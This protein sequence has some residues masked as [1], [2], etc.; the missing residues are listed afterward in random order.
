MRIK[1]R[2]KNWK[3]LEGYL[4]YGRQLRKDRLLAILWSNSE[5]IPFS[6]DFGQEIWYKQH[7]LEG[8]RRWGI[9][10]KHILWGS[11][12]GPHEVSFGEHDTY[13]FLSSVTRVGAPLSSLA[14]KR[15]PL[16]RVAEGRCWKGVW[17]WELSHP[18]SLASCCP[19]AGTSYLFP[20]LWFSDTSLAFWETEDPRHEEC[21]LRPSSQFPPCAEGVTNCP[22]RQ[23]VSILKMRAQKCRNNQQGQTPSP[24]LYISSG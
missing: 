11:L 15:P 22:W 23:D 6:P 7:F 16:G 5:S 19:N 3:L 13:W 12:Q 17:Q 10:G 18:F 24:D 14:H 8:S 9:C 4:V 20:W 2:L 1:R 21:D